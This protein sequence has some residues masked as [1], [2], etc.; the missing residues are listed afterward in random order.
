MCFPSIRFL[1]RISGDSDFDIFVIVVRL[2]AFNTHSCGHRLTSQVW[3]RNWDW[4]RFTF[5]PSPFFL[6]THLWIWVW[7]V[8]LNTEVSPLCFLVC[9]AGK[10]QHTPDRMMSLISLL[11]SVQT[12]WSSC[13]VFQGQNPHCRLE[14]YVFH[15]TD[16]SWTPWYRNSKEVVLAVAFC[17]VLSVVQLL[18]WVFS[19]YK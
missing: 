5:W 15:L 11:I 10:A 3:N 14:V 18:Y 16:F 17:F 4:M 19:L 7:T 9:M 8:A 13:A 2:I 6:N 1:E 12:I